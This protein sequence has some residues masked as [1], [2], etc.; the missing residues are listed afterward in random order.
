MPRDYLGG[1]E[2]NPESQEILEQVKIRLDLILLWLEKIDQR[3]KLEIPVKLNHPF[4][5]K[6]SHLFRSKVNHLFRTK[7]NH[8]I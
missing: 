6:L 8:L 5:F 2:L 3:P 7:V 4:R 1:E